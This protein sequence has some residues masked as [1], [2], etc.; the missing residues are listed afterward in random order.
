MDNGKKRGD[1][2][3][4]Y[5]KKKLSPEE[6]AARMADVNAWYEKQ[7]AMNYRTVPIEIPGKMLAA[8]GKLAMEQKV[9]F[10]EFIEEILDQYLKRQ[11]TPWRGR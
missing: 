8:L 6:H 10:S 3:G 2:S 11:G 5:A 4:W 1:I 7:H 9:P